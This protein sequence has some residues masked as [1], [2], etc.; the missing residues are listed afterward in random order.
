VRGFLQGISEAIYIFKA[1]PRS[2]KEPVEV[3]AH[4][5][6]A[7]LESAYRSYAPRISFP[8]YTN[9]P[10][11]KSPSTTCEQSRRRERKK[12]AGVRQ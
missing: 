10:A 12:G 7:L 8:P 6:K 5:D 9:C 11:S 2:D 3:D 1:I 4:A